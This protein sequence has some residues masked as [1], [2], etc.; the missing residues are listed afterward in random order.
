MLL[1][2]ASRASARCSRLPTTLGG[3]RR[4]GLSSAGP[5]KCPNANLEREGCGRMQH[6]RWR[7]WFIKQYWRN[8]AQ[9]VPSLGQAGWERHA[10]QAAGSCGRQGGT[11]PAAIGAQR[12]QCQPRSQAPGPRC[13]CRQRKRPRVW[14]ANRVMQARRLAQLPGN[15]SSS[16]LHYNWQ[17]CKSGGCVCSLEMGIVFTSQVG[18][19]LER[20]GSALCLSGRP[21]MMVC[22]QAAKSRH[23]H[24]A[25]RFGECADMAAPAGCFPSEFLLPP[26]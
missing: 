26:A 20:R 7:G 6:P 15:S 8:E 23:T 9:S 16:T 21:L 22:R 5:S 10:K 12:H 25:H 11:L 19:S 1:A 17:P 3:M 14:C 24:P 13:S 18:P 4:K 2:A